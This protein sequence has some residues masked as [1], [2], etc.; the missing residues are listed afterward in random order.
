MATTKNTAE[1]TAENRRDVFIEK[2]Q[3]NDEPNQYVS[4][5]GKNYLLPKGETSRVPEHIADE[6]ERSRR[7]RRR[8]DKNAEK[9][10]EKAKQPIEY[11]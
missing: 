11:K 9:L 6:I 1:N 10:L 7:A 3:V 2:G 8:Q 4:V 5:N